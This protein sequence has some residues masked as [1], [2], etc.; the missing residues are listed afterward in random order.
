MYTHPVIL[1]AIHRVLGRPFKLS[2]LNA[3][4]A[5][6]GLGLQ[7]LHADWSGPTNGQYHV[8]NSIWLLDDMDEGNG[9]TR[10]VPRTHLIHEPIGM[11]SDHDPMEPH[12]EEIKLVAPAGTVCVFN[13][14]VWHG[15]T[16]NVSKDRKRR[17]CHCYFTAREHDQQLNQQEYMRLETWKRI[18][19]SARYILDVD[20]D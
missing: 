16:R 6:P 15:G 13:S 12:P 5:V 9:C 14:H 11:V 20:I 8:C 19:Q 10:L 17:A 7:R 18:S 2:S 4:D 3:R 1:A